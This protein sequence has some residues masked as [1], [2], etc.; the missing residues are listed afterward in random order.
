MTA[1]LPHHVPC[2]QV[3]LEAV[4]GDTSASCV[5]LYVLVLEIAIVRT[6]FLPLLVPASMVP[7]HACLKHGIMALLH[8]L[9]NNSGVPES[10]VMLHWC[11]SV[12]MEQSSPCS[13]T[14]RLK[15]KLVAMPGSKQCAEGFA[16][17]SS[18]S[19]C[20]TSRLLQ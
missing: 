9:P 1:E 7:Q 10:A 17:A 19:S 15:M 14:C 6:S 11:M 20:M 3:K 16:P 13:T 2:L 12:P 4:S 5:W 8:T 18:H